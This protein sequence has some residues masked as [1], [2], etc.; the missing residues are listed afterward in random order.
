MVGANRPEPDTDTGAGT[1]RSPSGRQTALISLGQGATMVLGGVLALLVGQLFGKTADTDA[2]FAAYGLYAVGLVFAHTFR[3]TSVSALVMASG[4]ETITRLLGAVALMVAV[5]GVPMAA[6]AEPI[7]ALLVD[8]DPNGV[9]AET[10]RILWVTL[11]FQLFGAMLST[12]LMVRGSF[13]V[14]GVANLVTGFINIG[15]FL[16]LEGALGITAAAVGLAVG[17]AW[18][19]AVFGWVLLSDGRRPVPLSRESLRGIGSEAWHLTFASLTFFGATFAYVICVAVAARQ[20]PGE[21]TLFAYAFML[22]TIL[23]AVTSYVAASVHSPALLATD[24]RAAATAAAGVWSFRFTLVLIGPVI[25]M[26]LLIGEPVIAAALGS[27]F[28]TDD[29]RDILVTLLCLVLHVLASAAAVFAV[30][31]LLARGALLRLA[32]LAAAQIAA[33][34]PLTLLGAAVAGVQGVALALS[35]VTLGVAMAQLNWAFGAARREV[36]TAMARAAARELLV[37]VAAFAPAAA[38]L[39]ILGEGTAADVAAAVV[40]ALLVVAASVAAWPYESR[41]LLGLVRRSAASAQ[42]PAD[43]V[44]APVP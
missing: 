30:V 6:A 35:V 1:S 44:A 10:L 12:A 5:I 26:A 2:F 39:A 4:P 24:E 8:T 25:A 20:G 36:Q 37:L 31:E 3:L 27:E 15:A 13:T 23:V 42:G 19:T 18:L 38:L 22:A 9:A 17:G 34:L 29:I 14:I 41:A 16:L 33:L 7:G 28:S 21:A 11:A 40:A 43:R 32:V